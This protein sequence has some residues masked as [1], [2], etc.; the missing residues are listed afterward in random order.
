M[1][2]RRKPRQYRDGGRVSPVDMSDPVTPRSGEGEAP[3]AVGAAQPAP[4]GDDD[5]PVKRQLE[6]IKR[7]EDLQRQMVQR[8]AP[9][10]MESQMSAAGL[11][12]QAK[13]WMRAQPEYWTDQQKNSEINSLHGYLTNNKRIAPFSREY[14][15]RLEGELGMRPEPPRRSVA[16]AAPV[17]RGA[18]NLSEGGKVPSTIT[19]TPEERDMARRSYTWLPP[20]EAERL[21][22][23]MKRKML[24]AKA[25]GTLSQ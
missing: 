15:D 11:P 18:P 3:A 10:D 25:N 16:Y 19:L 13:A 6:A 1:A 14:F 7:A 5:S 8:P 20:A 9:T 4:T 23:E 17:T 12:D 24:I 21:F 2:V 22:A